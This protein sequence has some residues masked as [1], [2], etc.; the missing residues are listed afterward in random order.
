[1]RAALAL[2]QGFCMHLCMTAQLAFMEAHAA[3][4]SVCVCF[5]S[6]SMLW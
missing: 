3:A 6:T 1:V 4:R 5:A 2:S